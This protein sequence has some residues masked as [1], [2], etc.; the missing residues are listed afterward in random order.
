MTRLAKRMSRHCASG[1]LRGVRVSE[2]T[3]FETASRSCRLI[4]C[5][6]A[7]AWYCTEL[8]SDCSAVC[9][10]FTQRLTTSPL[11]GMRRTPETSAEAATKQLRSTSACFR[12][13][14]ICASSDG[15]VAA[16]IELSTR[17]ALARYR[18]TFEFMSFVRV[19]HTMITSSGL[20]LSSF[21]IR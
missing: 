13:R 14:S 1:D 21:R 6:S 18:S 19:A 3:T 15:S 2:A 9:T 11:T 10:S 12:C 8:L 20:G 4:W 7:S 5:S 17:M 16:M